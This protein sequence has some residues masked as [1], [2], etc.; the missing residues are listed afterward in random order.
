MATSPVEPGVGSVVSLKALE[1]EK[2]VIG[3][4]LKGGMGTVYQLIPVSLA[5]RPTALKTYQTTA[6]RSQFVREAEVWISLGSHPHIA[7]ARAYTEWRSKPAVIADWYSM[8]LAETD[9]S[10]W[11]SSH[12][13]TFVQRLIDGLTYALN[14]ARVIHQDIKPANVLLD[15]SKAP[16]ITDFGMAR[17]ASK[18]LS[19]S[20]IVDN[21]RST[22]SKSVCLG[23][24]GGTP[25]YMAPELFSGAPPS[26][27]TDIYS[28]GVTLYEALTG[29]HPFLGRETGYRFRPVLR[30]APL[31]LLIDRRGPEMKRL[32]AL[33]TAALRLQPQSR[34]CSYAN[35]LSVAGLRASSAEV[36][37]GVADIVVQ[38]AFLR[39]RNRYKEAETL[40]RDS[41]GDRP[42]NPVLLN[43]YAVLL[44]ASGRKSEARD[45]WKIAVESLRFTAGRHDHRLYLDPAA[46]LA[47]QMVIAEEFEQADELLKT[48]WSWWKQHSGSIVDLIDYPEFGWWHLYNGRFEDAC[49][50]ISTVYRSRAPDNASL[51]WLT[52]AAWLSGKFAE[53]TQRLA[54]LYLN[55][56]EANLLCALGACVVA[57][58]CPEELGSK[59]INVAYRGHT[60]ELSEI[61]RGLGLEPPTF[62]PK[63]ELAVCKTIIRSLDMRFTGGRNDGLIE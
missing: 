5:G 60:A 3:K 17:F 25:L 63:L 24:I 41:L 52:L 40:L 8:S 30:G 55:L 28:L 49:Q 33:I 45:M 44:L 21:V 1:N 27:R 7:H 42:T 20:W 34:P 43:S 15:D 54:E 26:V 14:V 50:H 46:N 38:A 35:L 9:L 37:D 59:L 62:R 36:Q 29:E 47:G 2:F 53:H 18:R 22:M 48:A 10:K 16:R 56:T 58:S 51:S 11:P 39:S 23:P 6:D 31:R 57:A 32:V 12:V 61:A 19:N 13:V 4:I